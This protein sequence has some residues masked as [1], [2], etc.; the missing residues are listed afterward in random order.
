MVCS[1]YDRNYISM[2][3][4]VRFAHAGLEKFCAE[5]PNCFCEV[6]DNSITVDCTISYKEK[7]ANLIEYRKCIAR[8][9]GLIY[10]Q[11]QR[12]HELKLRRKL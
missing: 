3:I 5:V 10:V 6:V 11:L 2:D 4:A 7:Q 9:Q 8:K 1:I 12:E